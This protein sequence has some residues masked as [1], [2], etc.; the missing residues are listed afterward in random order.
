MQRYVILNHDC[1]FEHWDLLLEAGEKCRTWRLHAAMDSSIDPIPAEVLNDHRSFYL[2]YEGPVGNDRGTVT[3]WDSGQFEWI[4][5]DAELC[6]V[7]LSG[8]RWSGK[9]ILRRQH[10]GGWEVHRR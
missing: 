1:P 2:D 10:N 9:V 3:R 6:E 4:H 8:S 5:N 7:V